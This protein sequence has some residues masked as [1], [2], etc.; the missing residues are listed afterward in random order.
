MRCGSV[1]GAG[2]VLGT[3][4]SF[5]TKISMSLQ[6]HPYGIHLLAYMGHVD[7]QCQVLYVIRPTPFCRVDL[8]TFVPL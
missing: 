7:H 4:P 2:H 1:L 5:P 8:P 6:L 3:E